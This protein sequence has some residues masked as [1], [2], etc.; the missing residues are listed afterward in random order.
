MNDEEIVSGFEA[1][2]QLSSKGAEF[3]TARNM[4]KLLGY[5]DW[6]NFEN[7]LERAA[8]SGKS[9]GVNSLNHFVGFT[10]MIETGKGAK[11]KYDD[12]YLSRFACYLIAMNGDPAKPE[13]AAAQQYFAVR[14][15]ERELAQKYLNARERVKLRDR[16]RVA[17]KHLAGAAKAAG[18]VEYGLFQHAG[19]MGLYGMGAED[20]KK[21]K[22][23]PPK[24]ELLDRAG[25]MELSANEFR[26]NLTENAL[27][28]EGGRSEQSARETHLRIGKGVRATVQRETGKSP[29]DLPTEPSI[30]KI[31]SVAKKKRGLPRPDSPANS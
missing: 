4:Q 31:I 27:K 12:F 8:T 23:I 20:V 19:Y 6:R 16:I 3:W 26:I 7:V 25:R 18:V 30:K 13:V 5:D 9:V 11:R 10:N 24:D 17:N 2:K 28:K 29:E 1:S 14:T 22:G 15:R 21:R